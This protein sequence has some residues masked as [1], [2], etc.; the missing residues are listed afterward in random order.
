MPVAKPRF[1]LKEE[2]KQIALGLDMPEIEIDG[3]SADEARL[4]SE[5]ARS[6]LNLLR[7][8]D[9]QPPWFDR[10][11]MLLDGGWPWRQ[12]CYIAW[13]S[14][15]KDGRVP[16]S[17]ELLAKDFLGLSSDR[18]ISTW[19]NKNTAIDSM[20]AVLQSAELWEHRADSFKNLI[21]GMKKSG[22]DYKYF[23]H[24]KLF[25]EM[26]GDYVPLNQIA[27]VIKAKADGGPQTVEEN[28]LDDLAEGAAELEE[29]VRVKNPLESAVDLVITADVNP[30]EDDSEEDAI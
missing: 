19:R 24:L 11:E 10:F 2:F 13:A 29:M 6:A 15:P 1:A 16:V 4:R 18:A 3:V 17:Q 8:T 14:M 7:S 5:T 25:M 28:T 23:N 22:G 27:A 21:D 26:S 12:A 20:I 30:V 9:K